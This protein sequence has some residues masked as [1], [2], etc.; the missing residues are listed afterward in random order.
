[1]QQKQLP[2]TVAQSLKFSHRSFRYQNYFLSQVY[3]QAYPTKHAT[4]QYWR[5]TACNLDSLATR[6]A[7]RYHTE[8]FMI[9]LSSYDST[10]MP[11]CDLTQQSMQ[12]CAVV[13]VGS[14]QGAQGARAPP[15]LG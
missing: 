9:A 10:S 1:M 8:Y 2:T 7:G 3:V 13:A 4:W 11:A 12:S 14:Q 15:K 6:Y 5:N